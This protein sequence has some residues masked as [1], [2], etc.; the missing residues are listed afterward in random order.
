MGWRIS[1]KTH[2]DNSR[3]KIKENH[4]TQDIWKYPCGL[5]CFYKMDVF[6]PVSLDRLASVSPVR[7]VIHVHANHKEHC[8]KGLGWAKN[9]SPVTLGSFKCNS[10][11]R[12]N[13]DKHRDTVI[14]HCKSMSVGISWNMFW[15]CRSCW[16]VPTWSAKVISATGSNAPQKLGVL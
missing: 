10:C 6:N 8:Q 4:S 16:S 9:A 12:I 14:S 11:G 5:F 15:C 7:R 2:K 3:R 1:T 13:M